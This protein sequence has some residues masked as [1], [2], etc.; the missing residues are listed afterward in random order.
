MFRERG[1]RIIDADLAFRSAEFE[2]V[3]QALPAGQSLLWALAKTNPALAAD[4]R[5]PGEDGKY[6]APKMDALGI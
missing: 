2:L 3:P 1:W 5:Y 6:E 4:L